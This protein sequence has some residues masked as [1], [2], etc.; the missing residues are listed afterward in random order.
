M[1]GHCEEGARPFHPLEAAERLP[2]GG[3]IDHGSYRMRH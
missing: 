3:I 1:N 2:Q